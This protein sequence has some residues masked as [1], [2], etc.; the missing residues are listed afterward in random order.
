LGKVIFKLE[1]DIPAFSARLSVLIF[2]FLV[3]HS[4]S[5]F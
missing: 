5:L 4:N 2:F 1:D 3:F